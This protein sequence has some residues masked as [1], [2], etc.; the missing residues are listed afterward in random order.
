MPTK[1]KSVFPFC[2]NMEDVKVS[3]ADLQKA[4]DECMAF[5]EAYV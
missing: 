2:K 1:E 4:G 3:P 5:C